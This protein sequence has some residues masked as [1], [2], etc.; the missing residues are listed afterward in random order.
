MACHIFCT[1]CLY[2]STVG[3]ALSNDMLVDLRANLAQP[4]RQFQRRAFGILHSFNATY[5]PSDT[6]RPLHLHMYRGPERF[7]LYD[8]NCSEL[9]CPWLFANVNRLV[10]MGTNIQFLLSD[11]YFAWRDHIGLPDSLLPGDN[12]NFTLWENVVTFSVKW[13]LALGHEDIMWDIYNEPNIGFENR[14]IFQFYEVWRRAYQIIKSFKS[15][16]IVIGPSVADL[17]WDDKVFPWIQKFLLVQAQKNLLPDILCWH[18][19]YSNGSD[20]VQQH[21]QIR[22]FLVAHNLFIPKIAHNEVIGPAG[23]L[24]PGVCV[25]FLANLE[26][27][28]V[29]HACRACWREYDPVSDKRY[30][31]CWDQT[32]DGLLTADGKFKPRSV[33]WVYQWY[34]EMNGHIYP[35]EGEM[36]QNAIDG[37]VVYNGSTI[38][39]LLGQIGDRADGL[40][41]NLTVANVTTWKRAALTA[42]WSPFTGM[43][44][45]LSP[46]VI[47]TQFQ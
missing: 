6:V 32:L 9:P 47:L 19:G 35:L 28:N 43:E 18:V 14:S 27:L 36:L 23:S 46:A 34:G 2:L 10:S 12:K 26:R 31:S 13:T 16:L 1:L 21:E 4:V 38:T 15:D 42:W 44:A 30:D 17:G 3:L 45:L 11:I 24:S 33:W 40:V 20:L 8:H 37:L 5:P 41:I 25:S 7:R 29:D 22:S 39:A